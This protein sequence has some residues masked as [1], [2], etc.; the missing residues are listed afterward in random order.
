MCKTNTPSNTAMRAFG[1]PPAM[2]VTENMIF[3][4]CCELGLD[5]VEFRRA[6]FYKGGETT[7]FGQ[8]LQVG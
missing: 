5:P 6:N 7:H 4:V 8:V 3:D 1:A 2:A